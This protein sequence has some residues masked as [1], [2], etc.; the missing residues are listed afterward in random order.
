MIRNN[1]GNFSNGLQK[2]F[3]AC[4]YNKKSGFLELCILQKTLSA[5]P[6]YAH[7]QNLLCESR[8]KFEY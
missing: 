7:R 2:I 1:F 5:I 3:H 8:Q 6:L 4:S